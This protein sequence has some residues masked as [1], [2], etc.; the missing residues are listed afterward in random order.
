MR[1]LITGAGGFIGATIAREAARKLPNA[2]IYAGLRGEGPVPEGT[3]PVII[4][5]AATAP[6]NLPKLDAIINAAGLG[7]Q[8]SLTPGVWAAQNVTA[9]N[10]L[11][12][13]AR[14]AGATKFIHISSAY[15]LGRTRPALITDDTSPAPADSYA[16]SKLAG[17]LAVKTSFGEGTAILRPAPVLGNGAKGNLPRLINL[18]ERNLPLPFGR[19]TAQRSMI[20]VEDL[21]SLALLLLASPAP[22]TPI[23]AAHPEPVTLPELVRALGLGLNRTPFLLPVPPFLLK[24][25]LGAAG[26]SALWQSIGENFHASPQAALG[27]SWTPLK[28]P[29]NSATEAARYHTTTHQT[30]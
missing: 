26:K 10:R 27:L 3:I 8:T 11:A 28:N 4:G 15:V 18:I 1:L 16:T 23:L 24:S 20:A 14:L 5:D 22:A 7:H 30:P 6:L 9:P 25:A 17:E 2:T 21:A 29:A 12:M 19:L 13:A